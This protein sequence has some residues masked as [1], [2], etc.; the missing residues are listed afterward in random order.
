MFTVA[1]DREPSFL[2]DA[3]EHGLHPRRL[4]EMCTEPGVVL[5]WGGE[6]A[7]IDTAWLRNMA[8]HATRDVGAYIR[9][10]ARYAAKVGK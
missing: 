10:L 5:A 2:A 6:P 3:H 1:T 4:G 9:A 7:P 8:V